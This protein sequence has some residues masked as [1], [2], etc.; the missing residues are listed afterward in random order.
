MRKEIV[1]GVGDF[2]IFFLR[3]ERA[4]LVP[5]IGGTPSPWQRVVP[6]NHDLRNRRFLMN[7]KVLRMRMAFVP[8]IALAIGLGGTATGL[9]QTPF[10]PFFEDFDTPFDDDPVTWVGIDVFDYTGNAV[11]TQITPIGDAVVLSN[12]AQIDPTPETAFSL[13][14][15]YVFKDGQPVIDGNVR[16]RAV[17]QVSDAEAFGSIA[18]RAQDYPPI[19]DAGAYFANINGSGRV[20]MGD[21]LD[22]TSFVVLPTALDPVANPVVLEFQVIGNVLTASAWDAA[23]PRPSSPPTVTLVDDV[24]RPPGLMDI[25]VGRFSTDPTGAEATFYSYEVVGIPEPATFVLLLLGLAT[26]WWRRRC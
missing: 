22:P 25:N 17:L 23:A 18:F 20:Q 19:G 26:A 4:F 7:D 11:T 2:S 9:G 24:A 13:G 12:P 6:P 8:A 1:G 10:F 21:F 5:V 15:A 3:I 14:A 16:A